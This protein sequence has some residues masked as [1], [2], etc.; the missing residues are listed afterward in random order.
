VDARKATGATTGVVLRYVEYGRPSLTQQAEACTEVQPMAGGRSGLVLGKFMPP[1]LGHAY[2]VDFAQNYVER[3]TVV[4]GTLEREPI[5]GDLRYA[6]M[7]ELFPR[8]NVVHLAEELPQEPSEH[9][10]FW[11]LWQASLKRVH[12]E[13]LDFVFASEPYG[14]KL[15]EVLGAEFVPVDIAR[16]LVPV[17]GSAVREDPLG[18]WRYIPPCVRPYFVK[19]V[20]LFGPESTGKSILAKRLAEHYET[21]YAEEYARPLLALKDNACGYGDIE[22]IGRGQWASEEALARQANRVLI[23]DTDMLTT[24]IWSEALFGKCPSWLKEEAARRRYDLTLLCDIDSP[25]HD[26]GTRFFPDDRE[27]FMRRCLKALG[28]GGRHYVKIGGTWDERFEG[29][30]EAIDALLTG[31]SRCGTAG[32][33]RT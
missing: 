17:T 32:A 14:F 24:S 4:V 29:A 15:A 16:S 9:P 27:G 3:V 33:F 8:A 19:R 11:A 20:C 31:P 1:H 26:D 25:W 2:L 5:P 13:P 28:D 21:V 12:P 22:R 23:S 30:C 10:D 18:H 7:K 6:W